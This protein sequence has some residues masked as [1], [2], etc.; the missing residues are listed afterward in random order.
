VDS[1]IA[2]RL[3]VPTKRKYYMIL[4]TG[5]DFI[6]QRVQFNA[7]KKDYEKI[8]A[9]LEFPK[10]LF[11]DRYSIQNRSET[12]KRRDIVNQWRKQLKEVEQRIAGSMNYKVLI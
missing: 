11:M 3:D 1:T 2:S 12:T 8:T 4:H 7:Q 6:V 5:I 9:P 10:E